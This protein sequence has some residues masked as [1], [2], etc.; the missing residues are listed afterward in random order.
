M[1]EDKTHR[2]EEKAND[3]SKQACILLIMGR[4]EPRNTG[5]ERDRQTDED[6]VLYC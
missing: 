1:E 5:L 4:E 3:K 6:M 2:A